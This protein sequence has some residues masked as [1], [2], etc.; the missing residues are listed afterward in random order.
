MKTIGLIGGMSWESTVNVIYDELCL[1]QVHQRSRSRIGTIIDTLVAEGAQGIILGCTELGLLIQ[2]PDCP[3]PLFD[4][5]Q[6]HALIKL[7]GQTRAAN[8]PRHRPRGGSLGGMG[9]LRTC[10]KCV[11]K[12]RGMIPSS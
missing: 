10:G 12:T 9:G 5:T 7:A 3:V 1:G 11:W 6:L 2:T 4:T 8:R